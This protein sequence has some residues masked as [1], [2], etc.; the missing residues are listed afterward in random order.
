MNLRFV[1]TTGFWWASW[2]WQ[3][4]WWLWWSTF[5]LILSFIDFLI[6]FW[7]PYD[8]TVWNLSCMLRYNVVVNLLLLLYNFV[9]FEPE[10]VLGFLV[11]CLLPSMK[12]FK[13]VSHVSDSSIGSKIL[14][15]IKLGPR[16]FS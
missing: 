1:A 8:E 12:C 10:I 3:R 7:N 9:F 14:A 16:N 6:V 15:S 4:I 13:L 2:L 11:L 5:K